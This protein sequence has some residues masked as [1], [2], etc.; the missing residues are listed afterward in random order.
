MQ[1][2]LWLAVACASLSLGASGCARRNVRTDEAMLGRVPMEQKQMVFTAENNVSVAQANVAAA[3]R[4]VDEAKDFRSVVDREL[5][6][7]KARLDAAQKGLKLGRSSGY[8]PTI[9]GS[10]SNLSIAQRQ[11]AAYQAKK[12]YGRSPGGSAREAARCRQQALRHREGR[13]RA[14]SCHR[15]RAQRHEAARGPGRDPQE[16]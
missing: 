4:S 16:P 14:R 1:R 3:E 7:A 6:A 11:L 13:P 2:T 5:D 8:Q 9:E 15:H 10:E 12:D